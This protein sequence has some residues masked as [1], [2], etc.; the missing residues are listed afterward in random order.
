MMVLTVGLIAGGVYQLRSASPDG[1]GRRGAP[2]AR[3]RA[4]EVVTTVATDAPFTPTIVA[5]GE[6]RAWRNLE[7]RAAAAGPISTLSPSFRDGAVVR[8]GE[9]LFEIDPRDAKR[10]VRDAEVALA[11]ANA[12]LSEAEDL[13][14]LKELEAVTAERQLELR[15]N[16]L[17]R[18]KRL[19]KQG[20]VS[21]T[22]AD[23]A[24][25]AVVTQ[26]QALATRRQVA[27][28][29][30]RRIEAAALARDRAQIALDD[31]RKALEDTAYRAPFDGP[32]AD[33]VA[34][35]G[36]RVAVNERLGLLIDPSAL[37]VA[38]RVRD[39]ELAR[40]SGPNGEL[41]D[42]PVTVLLS[43]GARTVN[44]KG[45]LARAAA[46]SDINEGGYTLYA[47]ITG[48]ADWTLRPGDFVEVQVNEPAL[49]GVLLPASAVNDAGQVF[50]V[51]DGN[52][53]REIDA[54]VLRRQG[55]NVL[56]SGL[57]E[58]AQIITSRQPYLARGV[59]V[60]PR[61]AEV[62]VASSSAAS[63]DGGPSAAAPVNPSGGR[64]P[65]SPEAAS[66]DNGLIALT[67]E[68]RANLVA[69]IE[70]RKRLPA[71]MKTRILD[72]LAQPEV[73]KRLVDR[74]EQRM[75]GG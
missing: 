66:D 49:N 41:L 25:M 71:P 13:L 45:Q 23:D 15:S 39:D 75:Q 47:H 63:G 19:S 30:R 18:K 46:T 51:A 4:F 22:E 58:A 48:Q 53:V 64:A 11:Q 10:G 27:L 26:E 16:E 72:R 62:Q 31:A 54:E 34:T 40:L 21:S 69:F 24:A 14:S 50:M 12:E 28:T 67:A 38:F 2:P 37:E 9:L 35:L 36:R 60:R 74:I 61:A 32:L 43:L 44:V 20:F 42:L 29:A 55:E 59:K 52:R 8:K 1:D 5:Y 68:R 6:V 57:P 70:S 33:V 7:I 56:V 17:E 3:E 73:P 65:A